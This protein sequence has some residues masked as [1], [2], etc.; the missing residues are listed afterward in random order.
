[1]SVIPF[2]HDRRS[3]RSNNTYEAIQ[4]QLAYILEEQGLLNFCLGDSRGLLMASAGRDDDAHVLAAYAPVIA[5][6][7]DK[8]RYQD[9]LDR[10]NQHVPE[11]SEQSVAFR[12][13]EVDG[14]TLHLCLLGE[15]GKLNH[16][17]IYRA[18][19]GVRRILDETRAAA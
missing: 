14:E 5:G 2:G 16:A 10:I 15:V 6:C 12:T 9:V 13:F 4:L 17:N 7:T 18:V 8:R 19:R 11:A 3:R 1:M